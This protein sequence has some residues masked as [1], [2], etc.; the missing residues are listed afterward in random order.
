MWSFN[1]VAMDALSRSLRRTSS[2][3]S[4]V[5]PE[6]LRSQ[7]ITKMMQ[8]FSCHQLGSAHLKQNSTISIGL[9]LK[10]KNGIEIWGDNL[11]FPLLKTMKSANYPVRLH[12]ISLLSYN[13]K[14]AYHCFINSVRLALKMRLKWLDGQLRILS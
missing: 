2:I 4:N 11:Y 14:F 10:V 3:S 7:P 12:S 9:F 5:Y 8:A 6:E 1:F 13:L